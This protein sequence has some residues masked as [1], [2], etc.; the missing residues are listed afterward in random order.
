MRSAFVNSLIEWS[1]KNPAPFLITGDLGYSVLEPFRD[2]FP[3]SFVNTG[4]MEQ[5]MVSFGAGLSLNSSRPIFLYS[6]NNFITFRALEQLRLDIG[7]HS[8]GICIVGV[9]AGFQYKSAGYSHWGIEDLAAVASLEKFRIS[10]PADSS[11][12]KAEVEEFLNFPK[13][14]YLR[15]GNIQS[16]LP[17]GTQF[18]EIP[19]VRMFGT[20]NR[21]ICVHGNIASELLNHRSYDPSKYSVYVFDR[22]P[23]YG[24]SALKKLL[25]KSKD[26][27]VVEEVVYSGSLGSRFAKIISESNSIVNFKWVGID[28]TKIGT[29]GG[30]IEFLRNRTLGQNYSQ[31]IFDAK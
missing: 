21:F 19:G 23:P 30:D 2:Q 4:I 6:I 8:L 11:G 12:V 13:P 15:L 28:G 5:S 14:T 10:V 7:Y 16:E 26:I 18:E 1:E 29:T 24:D 22:I 9:G 31:M 20:G 25:N 3:D 27:T 17:K